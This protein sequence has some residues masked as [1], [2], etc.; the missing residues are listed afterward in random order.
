MRA[1]LAGV[2]DWLANVPVDND[3]DRRNAPMLQ[4]VLLL[5]A[6][7]I[8]MLL[9]VR[10][11]QTWDAGLRSFDVV[12][13]VAFVALAWLCFGLVRLG[14]LRVAGWSLVA[15]SVV[16]LALDR[17]EYGLRPF[18][19]AQFAQGY[20]VLLA[21]CLFGRKA[22][23]WTASAIVT[24]LLIQFLRELVAAMAMTVLRAD[25]IAGLL[26]AALGLAIVATICDRFVVA[27][28][29]ADRNA[30][31]RTTDMLRAR[32]RLEREMIEKERL[33]AQLVHAQKMEVV[34]KLAGGIAHDFNNLLG[35]VL[36]YAGRLD[37]R[38]DDP[39][40]RAMIAGIVT[41]AQRGASIT[42]RL[43]DLER[44]DDARLRV[45]DVRRAIADTLPMVRQLFERS[46][47]IE[48]K[49]DAGGRDLIRAD[50]AEFQLAV[51][52][53]AANARDAMPDGGC[54]R[55]ALTRVGAD[56]VAIEFSDTGMGMP[57]AVRKRVFEPFFTT[58]P[59]GQGTGIG[60]AVVHRT[61]TDSG[62][63]VAIDSTPGQ[64]TTLRLVLP[65]IRTSAGEPR[66]QSTGAEPATR[67][68]VVLLVDDDDELR[69]VLA[70]T[71]RQRGWIVHVA[72][73]AGQ[74]L[75]YA[76]LLDGDVDAI[77]TDYHLPDQPV[78][79]M[80]GVLCR[81][82]P[83]ARAVVMSDDLLVGDRLWPGMVPPDFL[84]KPFLPAQLMRLLLPDDGH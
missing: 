66:A 26:R 52:N 57:E 50:P 54:F 17:F 79:G 58:K 11:V 44:R 56:R 3:R 2:R 8:P 29:N 51:L 55:I 62:G 37:A 9:V 21:G 48:F 15:G 83:E 20:P 42:R 75:D 22:L 38:N 14:Q 65:V 77:V 16:L 74:A 40:A 69:Q 67:P 68:W 78:E 35:V 64:G 46:V 10:V 13:P 41:A 23:W 80:L 33:Q 5:L 6:M 30:Q 76:A 43:L 27:L 36:G 39:A 12:L 7:V 81:R 4:C 32:E 82:W 25:A 18:L 53:I 60:L 47:R 70:A 73:D 28:G 34:G 24:L 63:H 1:G 61:M 45:F 19:L 71:M 49:D 72:A 31:R 84:A 59:I